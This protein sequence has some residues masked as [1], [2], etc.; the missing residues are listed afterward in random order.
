MAANRKFTLLDGMIVIAA[1]AISLWVLPENS[2]PALQSAIR[3][4]IQYHSLALVIHW[5]DAIVRKF[6]PP[7]LFVWTLTVLVLEAR[8]FR[9]PIRRLAVQPGF[10][11]CAVVTLVMMMVG[12]LAFAS[13]TIHFRDRPPFSVMGRIY[14]A[15]AATFCRL[16]NGAAVT[17]AWATLALCRLWRARADWLDRTG[18]MIGSLWLALISLAW[19]NALFGLK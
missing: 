19:V 12:P 9:P 6:V 3:V 13:S 5:T 8:H 15:E 16:Q 11:A 18:R 10:L 7:V 4:V 17:A 1:L 14:V 2:V